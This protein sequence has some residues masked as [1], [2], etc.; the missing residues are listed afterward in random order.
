MK[1]WHRVRH[2]FRLGLYDTAIGI[3]MIVGSIGVSIGLV[4]L[5]EEFR[6]W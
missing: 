5:F 2:E 3:F 1:K 4:F 6:G